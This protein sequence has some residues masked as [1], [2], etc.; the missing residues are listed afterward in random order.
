MT[1]S[2]LSVTRYIKNS[3]AK[4]DFTSPTRLA[5]T[6]HQDGVV[7]HDSWYMYV[8]QVMSDVCPANPDQ[9]EVIP[10]M[11]RAVNLCVNWFYA[12]SRNDY[13]F[14]FIAVRFSFGRSSAL[15]FFVLLKGVYWKML[16][17]CEGYRLQNKQPL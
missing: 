12:I 16:I 1:R 15:D 4:I 17:I 10:H 3:K 6:N 11:P 8:V 5:L 14:R 7:I 2:V 13:V 9:T